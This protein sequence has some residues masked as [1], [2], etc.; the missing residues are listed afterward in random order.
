MCNSKLVFVAGF[1]GKNTLCLQ[2]HQSACARYKEEYRLAHKTGLG[3]SWTEF[4]FISNFWQKQTFWI[5]DVQILKIAM[6]SV[7]CSTQ[8]TMSIACSVFCGR[9]GTPRKDM[10]LFPL[11]QLTV[12]IKNNR[13]DRF[14]PIY[15]ETKIPT[16]AGRDNV[17]DL[18]NHAHTLGSQWE[19]TCAD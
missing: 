7:L 4:H 2:N 15:Q 14:I 12:D 16:L 8:D 9:T 17:I 1:L 5:S 11:L 18:E 13:F 19:C 6:K 10:N 3:T